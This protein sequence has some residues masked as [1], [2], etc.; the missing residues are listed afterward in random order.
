MSNYST[1]LDAHGAIGTIDRPHRKGFWSRFYDRLV[2][3]RQA[4]AQRKLESYFASLSEAQ[5]KDPGFP[6]AADSQR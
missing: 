2:A 3:A 6:T 5:R 4:E 1:T